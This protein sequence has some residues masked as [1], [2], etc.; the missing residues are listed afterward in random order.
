MSVPHVT[1]AKFTEP[2]CSKLSLTGEVNCNQP[3]QSR[4]GYIA[5]W[6]ATV[7]GL[8]TIKINPEVQKGKERLGHLANFIF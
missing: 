5:F 1:A 2:S 4:I 6:A 8:I 3:L 7:P